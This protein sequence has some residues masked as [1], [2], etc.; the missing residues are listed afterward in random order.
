MVG[1][2]PY[3]SNTNIQ[4]DPLLQNL[5]PGNGGGFFNNRLFNLSLFGRNYKENA[6]KNAKG[7]HANED[8]TIRDTAGNGYTIFSRKAHAMM[9]EKQTIASLNG[10]YIQ[11]LPILREY[12]TK[13]EIS[14]FVTNMTNELVVYEDDKM[15]CQLKPLPKTLPES[16][17]QK[18]NSIFENIYTFSGFSDGT[19][20]WDIA[21]DWLIEGYICR[22]IIYDKKGKNIIGT[23]KLDPLSI[24][25][26][27][28]P[29]SSLKI[30][31]QHPYGDEENRRIFVDAEIIYISYSGGSN[32]MET[33]YVEPLIR[34]YNELKSIERSRILF[35]LI[36][37]T[38]H[39][40]FII[41]THG[42]SPQLA[43]QEVLNLISDYKDMITFDDS[44]GIT[45][46]DGQKDLP[47]SKE[48]WLPNNG[49]ASPE[50]DIIDPAG[51]DL[52]ENSMLV[53]FKNALKE[54]SKFPLSRLDTTIG[55]GNIYSLGQEL[56]HDDYNFQQ[57][58][59]RLRTLF[60][61]IILKPI[62]LQF[63]LDFPEYEQDYKLLNDIDIEFFGHSELVKAKKLANMEAR[64]NIAS[65]LQN[66][67]KREED[68]P[69][70][71]WKMI[72][73][74]IMEFDDE[75]MEENERYYKEDGDG[76]G[77]GDGDG[78]SDMGGGGLEPGMDDLGESEDFDM[79]NTDVDTDI[80]T[81]G[82][83]VVEDAGGDDI[84]EDTE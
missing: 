13:I 60:K 41:P 68:K 70:L 18:I 26:I 33:S 9:Q 61:Q 53:Y 3:R 45:Y 44:T 56:T 16:V 46:I 15:F 54:A 10:H 52:N 32:F 59:S 38:M 77:P 17:K 47:Y 67:L 31:V 14:R 21:R 72:A 23:Q 27:I 62:I 58:I 39:K 82:D 36:N 81:S 24:V 29:V 35:N 83:D 2:N 5:T 37:A 63:L 12:A 71:H 43:E 25:P 34:P 48:Y 78:G 75:F 66:N 30:W 76:G 64:S 1:Y 69:I 4:N 65:T 55:G 20:A 57:Y 74:Y 50:I 11:T 49:E 22:E 84:V 28:D 51:H 7:I 40:K 6:V 73:K 42:L 8:L 19:M 79:D 80:D